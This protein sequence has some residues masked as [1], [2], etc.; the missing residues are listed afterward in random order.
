MSRRSR[1]IASAPCN[2]CTTS[3]GIADT[4][5]QKTGALIPNPNHM[6]ASSA[7]M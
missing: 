6:T 1:G 7:H 3:P 5:A 2:T 4:T